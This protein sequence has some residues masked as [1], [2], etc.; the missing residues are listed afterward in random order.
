M[1][2]RVSILLSIT[3]FYIL[4]FS[5]A[6]SGDTYKS[7]YIGQEL[8]EIKSLSKADIEELIN[9]RGWGLAKAAELNGV[10][11]PIHLLEMQK[12]IKLTSKQIQRSEAIFQEMKQKAIK[13]G[14]KLIDLERELNRH[15]A[16]K[17]ITDQLLFD[18]LDKIAKTYKKLR[19]IHLSAHLKTPNILTS[20]Q[21]LLYNKLRGYSMDEPCNN[22]PKGHNPAMWKKHHN[23]P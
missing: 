23:C 20:D 4:F 6:A 9:G 19:Y 7:K 11:G 14:V 1:K 10:P 18:L 22:I 15:F 17:T 3:L 5:L 2:N 8:R 16:N 21:I 13:S 12:E